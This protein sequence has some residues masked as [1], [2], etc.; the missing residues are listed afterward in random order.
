MINSTCKGT[1]LVTR[2]QDI[3]SG[4][5]D[6]AVGSQKSFFERAENVRLQPLAVNQNPATIWLATFLPKRRQVNR[7]LKSIIYLSSC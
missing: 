1:K 5:S 3:K 2:N 7:G 4:Q 6:F